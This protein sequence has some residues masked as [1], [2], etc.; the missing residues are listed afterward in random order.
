MSLLGHVHED[1]PSAVRP[2]K[3]PA[4]STDLA[5]ATLL[6][7]ASSIDPSLEREQLFSLSIP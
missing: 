7:L 5:S 6:E 4:D 1:I 3:D 2:C